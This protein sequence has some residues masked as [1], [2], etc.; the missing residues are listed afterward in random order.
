MRTKIENYRTG[1]LGTAKVLGGREI[2]I[3]SGPDEVPEA[4]AVEDV[5][6]VVVPAKQSVGAKAG[7][8]FLCVALDAVWE[9]H[10]EPTLGFTFDLYR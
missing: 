5:H 3:R 9:S 7:Y 4:F 6:R 1:R 8:L 10:L 2:S